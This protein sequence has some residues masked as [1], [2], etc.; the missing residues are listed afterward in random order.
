MLRRA[1]G[2]NLDTKYVGLLDETHFD[3][4]VVHQTLPVLDAQSRALT[5]TYTLTFV[6]DLN[7]LQI[8]VKL[9]HFG[10]TTR[11]QF[12]LLLNRSSVELICDEVGC[13]V[14]ACK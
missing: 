9:K 12:L 3:N 1:R 2:T 10:G 7:L 6:V 8:R 11:Y 14:G 5:T 4:V 13:C